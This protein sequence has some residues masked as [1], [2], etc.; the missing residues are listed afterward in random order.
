MS[1][2]VTAADISKAFNTLMVSC[3]AIK[4]RDRCDECPMRYVCLDDTEESVIS[5]ADL[6]SAS[7]WEEF[8]TFADNATFRDE[9]LKSQY[10]DFRRKLYIEEREIE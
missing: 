7:S 2:S 3:E 10:E 5:I 8:L 1:N 6:I 9:D 4:E